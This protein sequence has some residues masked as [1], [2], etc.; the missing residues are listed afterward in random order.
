MDQQ[1]SLNEDYI[2]STVPEENI[3][4]TFEEERHKVLNFLRAD[5]GKFHKAAEIAQKVGFPTRGTQVEVRKAVTQ[6]IE[7]DEEPIIATARGFAYA[8]HPNQLK[9]YADSLDERKQGLQRRIDKV[10]QIH[11]RYK[12]K[13]EI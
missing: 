11:E 6:L 7:I 13:E 10:R 9:F 1:A 3:D 2:Y 8:S 5:K 12:D 4:S